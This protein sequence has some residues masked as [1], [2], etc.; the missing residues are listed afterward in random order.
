MRKAPWEVQVPQ[1]AIQKIDSAII[2]Q[3]GGFFNERF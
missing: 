3:K 1:G 2:A